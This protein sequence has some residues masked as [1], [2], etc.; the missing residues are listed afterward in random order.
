MRL[1]LIAFSIVGICV[2]VM[3]LSGF[4][5]GLK[6]KGNET[7]PTAPSEGVELLKQY[8]G[9]YVVPTDKKEIFLTFDL[10]YEAGYTNDVLD[11]L[12]K[13]D[14]RAIFFLCGHYLNETELVQR[15][16]DDGHM[17]G[18]HTD[19]HKNLPTLDD[20]GIREDIVNF[21]KKFKEKFSHDIKFF[22]PGAGKFDERTLKIAGDLDLR[23]MMWSNAIVDWEKKPIKP[24]KSA[25]KI[26]ERI[27]PGCILLL[28]IAN[29]GTPPMLEIFFEKIVGKGY[30]IGDPFVI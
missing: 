15:M 12:K 17:I 6:H 21:D 16:I 18:N 29:S 19:K 28:H 20:D 23:T 27:H 22:R 25:K 24:E 1:L 10:G 9:L 13:N 11:V 4:S 26:I 14:V 30:T 8:D 7:I 3:A 5:W 2:I